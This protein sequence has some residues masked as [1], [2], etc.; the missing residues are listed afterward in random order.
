[1]VIV[2]DKASSNVFNIE[3]VAIENLLKNRFFF[4]KSVELDQMLVEL[5]KLGSN[6][7]AL[8]LTCIVNQSF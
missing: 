3:S 8:P 4:Q 6:A 5:I 1:M 2:E 7:F